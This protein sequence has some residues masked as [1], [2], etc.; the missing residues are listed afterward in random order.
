MHVLKFCAG[1][2]VAV[3]MLAAACSKAP[4]APT[5]PPPPPPPP[6]ADAP[7]ITCGAGINRA[8]VNAAGMAI[9]YDTPPVEKGQGSVS[10]T[11]TPPS[12]Q[13]FPI[14]TTEVTCTATDTLNRSASCSFTVSIS[15]L[16]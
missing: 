10:V 12:G 4:T 6:V 13:T 8:T 16:P 15:K 2:N 5:P 9:N 1:V 14:G 11:C 7:T 3:L